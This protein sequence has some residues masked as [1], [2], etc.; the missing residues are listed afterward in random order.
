MS[1]MRA[2]MAFAM[3]APALRSGAAVV[4]PWTPLD[5][6]AALKAWWNADDHGTARMTD[7]GAGLISS[8]TDKVGSMAIAGAT[9]ARP[10]WSATSFNTSYA[11]LTFNGTANALSSTTLTTLPTGATAG[12]LWALLTQLMPVGTA[13]IKHAVAYGINN[14]SAARILGRAVATL[15]RI[16][17][18]E[19]ATTITDTLIDF[20]SPAIV[21]GAWSGTSMTARA[22]GAATTPASAVIAALNTSTTRFVIG[23]SSSLTAFAN[24]VVRHVF[25]TTTLT[26][27]QRQQLEGWM[28]WDAS[29]TGLLPAGHPYKSARP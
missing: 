17:V 15:N 21:G 4:P 2:R 18:S 28:A 1:V 11:G 19:A 22:N 29:L 6:G 8:W 25:V 13:G 5:L 20:S 23:A 16:I 26:T 3:N 14:P 9:T 7:D 27:L 12:E 24:V 10:T